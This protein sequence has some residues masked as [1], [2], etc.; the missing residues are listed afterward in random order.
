MAKARALD[1]RRKSIKNI[2]ATLRRILA[3]A[4]EWE[5]I[6]RIP[7]LPKV[8]VADKG[9]DFLSREEATKLLA[10]CRDA[11]N[12]PRDEQPL[13]LGG[14]VDGQRT[15]P[16][17][18][19]AESPVVVEDDSGEGGSREPL[20]ESP[21]AAID[22]TTCA[23][24][25]CIGAAGDGMTE[26]GGCARGCGSTGNGLRAWSGRRILRARGVFLRAGEPRSSP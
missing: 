19:V 15:S 23:A 25:Y 17:P 1:K 26:R 10:A 2:R 6:D 16:T 13:D 18:L 14:H 3:S 11:D 4:A 12:R 24:G 9:W 20:D 22:S 7:M 5:F 21:R 8:K